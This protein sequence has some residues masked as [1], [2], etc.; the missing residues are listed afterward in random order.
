MKVNINGM[1]RV[2]RFRR[3]SIRVKSVE[4]NADPPTGDES[5]W[6]RSGPAEETGPDRLAVRGVKFMK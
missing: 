2:G 3:I 5:V 1:L 4:K 6:P